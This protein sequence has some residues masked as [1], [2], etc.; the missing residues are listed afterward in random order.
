MYAGSS[1]NIKRRMADPMHPLNVL[2][3]QYPWPHSVY[4]RM[5]FCDN[6]LEREIQF[7][8]LFKPPMNRQYNG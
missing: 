4:L 3:E 1:K 6:Y 5:F 2:R 8:R 7:I